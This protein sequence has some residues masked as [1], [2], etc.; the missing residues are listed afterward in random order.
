MAIGI[1]KLLGF[2][3][4]NNFDYPYQSTSMTEFW[5]KWHITLGQWF[6]KYIYF[7]L[8][9]SKKGKFITLR[10]MFVVW[11]FT[12]LWHGANYN[13]IIWGI[14]LFLILVIEKNFIKKYLDKYKILG[15]MYMIILIPI[16]IFALSD[17][18][19]LSLLFNKLTH[20]TTKGLIEYDYIKYITKY[21]LLLVLGIIFCTKL[22]LAIYKKNKFKILE[23]IV[24]LSIFWI[25]IYFICTQS[26]D[27]F[28][29]FSF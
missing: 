23:L 3:L 12:G 11:L 20:F 1:S 29:Y 21:G 8:G 13:F 9:G 28:M 16:T 25:S 27:P 7:P 26:S 14:A 22:P 19:I 10:N 15:H 17:F 2:N 5:R 24:L 4:P 18:N 6:K